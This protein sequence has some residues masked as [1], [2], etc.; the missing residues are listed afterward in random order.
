MKINPKINKQVNNS[1]AECRKTIVKATI[2]LLKKIQKEPGQEIL[3]RRVLLLHNFKGE[4]TETRP[5]D[6]IVF[7]DTESFFI[8]SLGDDYPASSFFLTIDNLLLI[9]KEVKEIVS[10]Y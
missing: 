6:R 10:A 8:T 9:Y 5:A 1:V 2:E 4:R 7:S 3:F